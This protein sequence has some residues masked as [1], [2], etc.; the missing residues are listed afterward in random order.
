MSATPKLGLVSQKEYVERRAAPDRLRGEEALRARGLT[1]AMLASGI[2]F[3]YGILDKID[4]TLLGEGTERLSQQ[5][6]LANL[7]TI[8]GNLIRSGIA[9]HSDG[10]F[11]ANGPHKYPDLK[12]AGTEDEGLEIK[13]ALEKNSPKGHLPKVGEHLTIRYVLGGSDGEYVPG[14]ESRGD[15]VW[16]WEVRVGTLEEH[17]FNISNTPGDSG[18]TAVINAAGLA[19]LDVVYFDPRF[20]PLPQ[21]GRLFK[22]YASLYA[23][24]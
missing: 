10:H 8:F 17:H 16:V 9:Q 24:R 14:K 11:V 19:A 5:V 4:A 6:E 13:V 1:S 12:V 7:S 22:A 23:T 21:A 20:C 2:D 3:A 18:K 15:V